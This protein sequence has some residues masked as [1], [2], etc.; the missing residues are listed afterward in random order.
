MKIGHIHLK[1][2][3]LG[4][5]A[6]FYQEFLDMKERERIGN[7]FVFLSG[8]DVHHEV[9]LQEVGE[10]A[11]SPGRYDVGLFH[12]A[13]EV[14]DRKALALAYKKLK[15]NDIPVLVVDHRIS[16]AIYFFD[17]DGNGLE[18]YWDARYQKDGALLWEGRDRP[19][20][21]E[22]LLSFLKD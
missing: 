20:S 2:R 21:E 19:L 12:T 14:P 11:K 18:I 16:W 13:F 3:D 10:D 7:H 22:K 15:G 1:V 17:P 6:R 8:T 5:S 4:R 9:A